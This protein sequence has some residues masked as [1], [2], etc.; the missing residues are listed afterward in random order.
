LTSFPLTANVVHDLRIDHDGYQSIFMAVS[1]QHWG[2][3]RQSR[4]AQLS[5]TLVAGESRELPAFPPDP[6]V[7]LAAGGAGQ[8][9][10]K[11]ETEPSGSQVWLLVGFT[12]E[13]QVG[14]IP[15]GN[16]YE[17]MLLK[18]GFQPAFASFKASDW[19]L[20]GL[21]GPVKPSLSQSVSLVKS[22]DSSAS[23]KRRRKGRRRR[24]KRR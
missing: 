2:G 16:D 1:A 14:G 10:L 8:G 20:S 7:P 15:A 4:A 6:E 12:P 11:V 3:D 21:D 18:D 23:G 5:A 19:Y 17:F 24:D 13:V 22:K 9:P